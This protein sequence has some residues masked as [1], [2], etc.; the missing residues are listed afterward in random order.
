MFLLE[1]PKIQGAKFASKEFI[2]FDTDRFEL[3]LAYFVKTLKFYKEP[4]N[5]VR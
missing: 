1:H 3:D 5:R 4:E 2:Y